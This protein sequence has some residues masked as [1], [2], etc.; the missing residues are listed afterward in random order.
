MARPQFSSRFATL[1]AMAAFAVGVGNVWRF[2]YMMGQN[3]GS[4][5]LMIYLAFVIALAVPAL[6]GEWSLGRATRSGPITAFRAALGPRLGL[7][8][9]FVFLFSTF[10]AL[11]YYTIVVGN[12]IY[13]SWFA[14]RHG[15]DPQ[16]IP[17]YEQGLGDNGLQFIYAIALTAACLWIVHRGLKRGIE[18]VNIILMPLFAVV[19]VYMVG[20]TL[21]L[22]GAA[23]RLVEFLKPDFSQ[24]GPSVWF[25]AMG[26]ACFSIGISGSIGV[27]YGSYLREQERLVPSAVATGFIDTGAAL[28]A[29]LFVVPAVLVFG[30]NL[31]AGPTLLFNTL[32]HL[33][34]VMPGGRWLAGPFLAAWA[35]VAVLTIVAA[36]EAVIGALHDYTGE[37]VTRNAWIGITGVALIVVMLPTAFNP[38]VIGTLDLIFGSG[39]FMLGSLMAVIAVGWGLGEAVL[40]AQITLGLKPHSIK[41]MS[42]WIRYVVPVAMFVILAGFI[43]QGVGLV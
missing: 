25:A 36:F 41:F 34:E 9:G 32:P 28:M 39:M 10:V 35:M 43:L 26:Q 40:K 16:T 24:A 2:P 19:V 37:K 33:F 1:L 22:D 6:V 23:E 17:A 12:V 5:F 31:A 30:L 29:S 7:G 3:G 14:L 4:A 18:A 15:F 38:Q 20:V 8:L 21:T 11:S 27:L 42:N 13:T